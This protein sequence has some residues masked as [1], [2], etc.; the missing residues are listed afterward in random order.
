MNAYAREVSLGSILAAD[1]II[2][3]MTNRSKKAV[4]EDL[5]EVLWQKKMI[6]NKTEALTRIIERE[7]LVT[8]ALGDGV[9]LPHARLDVGEK[10]VIAMGRHP[11]GIDFGAPDKKPVKLIFL[12]LWKPEQAGLM[13]RL[14]A[15]LV[16][17]L[18]S[19]EFRDKILEAKDAKAIARLLSDVKIDMQSGRI[20][21]C[22][23]DMLVALQL[24]AVKRRAGAKGL[25]RQIA[26]ARDEIPGSMLSRFDR[27]IER[28]GEALVEAPNGICGGC[29][30]QLSS[31]FASEVLKN[32]DTVYVCEKCGKFLIHHIG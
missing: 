8:T 17:K 1:Q 15:G 25:D 7:D 5:I 10:P 13:N 24:L 3:N 32:S 14:F 27:L 21:K 2:D 20:A 30:M 26:I 22:E 31:S 19:S 11:S 12:L 9:A 4:F 6:S 29:N 18:A 23:V 16:S 28:Y